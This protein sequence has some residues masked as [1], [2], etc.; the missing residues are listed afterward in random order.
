MLATTIEHTH[1][2]KYIHKNT[3]ANKWKNTDWN[4]GQFIFERT[5][6][7]YS[8]TMC[9]EAHHINIYNRWNMMVFFTLF[10]IRQK[11]QQR[12][13]FAES[14]FLL[15]KRKAQCLTQFMYMYSIWKSLCVNILLFLLILY[16]H[17]SWKSVKAFRFIFGYGFSFFSSFFSIFIRT[18]ILYY[19]ERVTACDCVW[20]SIQRHNDFDKYI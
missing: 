2:H 4:E 5:C 6:I 1:T 16:L 9:S 13:E 18:E 11:Q 15:D 10:E 14:F 3:E 20:K 8:F 7:Y 19:L 12:N 17:H